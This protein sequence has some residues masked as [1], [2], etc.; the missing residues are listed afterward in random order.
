MAL[1]GLA[2]AAMFTGDAPP[3]SAPRRREPGRRP[4]LAR[5]V[6]PGPGA[7][8]PGLG[9]SNAGGVRGQRPSATEALGLFEALGDTG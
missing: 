4:G 6:G 8:L 5:S 2:Y 3:A 1:L 9:A 7:V